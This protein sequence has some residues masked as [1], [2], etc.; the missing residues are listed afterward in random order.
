MNP[1]S[2]LPL[3]SS[4]GRKRRRSWVGEGKAHIEVKTA[5]RE[6]SESLHERLRH[7]LESLDGVDW[8]EV[9]AVAGRVVVA[10]D[11]DVVDP[12]D[13]IDAVEE[14]EEAHGVDAE[15]FSHDAAEHPGD[16][17]TVRRAVL[18]L[19]ADV[20]AV[21]VSFAGALLRSTPIPVE[22]GSVASFVDEQP[23]VRRV[24]EDA[25]GPTVADL[26]LALGNAV[27][28]ALSQGP[29]GLLVDAL[30]RVN[31]LTAARANA[32]VWAT[33]EPAL[34]ATPNRLTTAPV[35]RVPRPRP[36]PRGPV[37]TYQ[38]RASSASLIGGAITLIA[39]RAPRRAATLMLAG[40]AKPS[41]M[42]RDAFTAQL[43][44]ALADRD[45]IVL[46]SRALGR[47]DRVDTVLVS[48]GLLVGDRVR[49]DSV[50]C[51][52]DVDRAEVHRHVRRLFQPDSP[53]AVHRDR[54]WSL[55]PVSRLAYA[56]SE[57]DAALLESLGAVR[58]LGLCRDERL[59]AVFDTAP[60]TA[61][62]AH[63]L[64]DAARQA[65]HMVAVAGDDLDLVNR[66]H[67]D[68]LVDGGPRLA[69]S[70]RMLQEDGCTV[71]LVSGAD[72]EALVAADVAVG[73]VTDHAPWGAD[74]FCHLLEDARRLVDASDLAQEV[75][76]QGN[77][78]ALSAS[79]VAS[80][81]ALSSP[82]RVAAARATTTI[83]AAALLAMANGTR[84][85]VAWDRRPALGEG[86][87]P[88]WHELSRP[89]VLHMLDTSLAGL[90]QEHEDARRLAVHGTLP[91]PVALLRAIGSELANPFTPVL[92]G[93]ALLS[94][95]VGSAADAAIVLAALGL[96]GVVSGVQR[97]SGEQAV[98]SLL[99][100]AAI[101]THVRRDGDT[102]KLTADRLVS[103]DIVV[104][105][106]G[107]TVPADCRI[108]QV[109]ALE[110]DESSL[111]G[112]SEP[113]DKTARAVF[114]LLVS[115]RSCMLYEGTTIVAGS[116]V[117]VVVATDQETESAAREVAG[118]PPGA[119]V[120]VEQRL[121][122]LGAVSLP[123][124]GASGAVM[125]TS[126]LLWG[127]P[128]REALASAVSLTV[129][130]VP[131]GLPMLATVGQ[132]AAARRLSRQGVLVRNPRAIEALGRAE[133]LCVDKTGTLT[134]GR[135]EVRMVSDG[136]RSVGRDELGERERLVLAAARRA[137]PGTDGERSLPH[138]TDRAVH[139]ASS[140]AEIDE[141]LGA[142][143]WQRTIELPFGPDRPYHA[144]WGTVAGGVRLSVKGAPEYV[145]ERSR[146]WR[147]ADG[148]VAIGEDEL[149]RL[150][151]HV[152]GLARRGLRLLAVAERDLEGEDSSP[153]DPS[154]DDIAGLTL[155][156]FV[157][158]ADPIRETATSAIDGLR[159][160][161]VD[162]VMVTGDHPSTAEGIAAE[163]G[164]LDDRRVVTG[165]QLEAMGDVELDVVLAETSVFARVT[166]RQKV[167]IVAAFQR[168]GR[169]VAMTGDGAND[170]NAMRLADAGIALGAHCAPA[171]RTAADVIITDNRIETIVETII[172]G[173]ALWAAVRD[174]L[175]ILVGGNL[176]EIAF[177]LLSGGLGRRPSLS[178]RQILL[179]NLL[180]DIAPSLAIAA[181]PPANRSPEQLAQEGPDRSLGTPLNRAIVQ[182]AA[183]T[184][185][186]ASTAWGIARLSGRPKRAGT[187]GLVA[188]VGTQ[189]GQTLVMGRGDPVV[190]A[191]AVGSAALLAAIVET[192][193]L[194]QFFDCTPLGPV[195]WTT[196]I[197]AS[198][199][200]TAAAQYAPALIDR[201]TP[202]I[203]ELQV[204]ATA[205]SDGA[206]R[207]AQGLGTAPRL[208][209][210]GAPRPRDS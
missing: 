198:A 144:T 61:R 14:I 56:A 77:A 199:A 180:T 183:V 103:G 210:V 178:T 70:V 59:L 82:I 63:Q 170:A 107:E 92:V 29:L 36:L 32:R 4:R 84:A 149:A 40:M 97:F 108:L 187:V 109:N 128:L 6:G 160:A 207:V 31:V 85:A 21:G 7:G 126:Q 191:A 151:E 192:P 117:A 48:Q 201:M 10:F 165:T 88:R 112:E 122:A 173:R 24:V 33:H 186:G 62:G 155:L 133:V 34:V 95:T 12:A 169:P 98:R 154:D 189:L 22:V 119:D 43:G 161:G 138:F 44:R 66:L 39:T 124:A 23:K 83:N 20:I 64:L 181:R 99:S 125:A 177:I 188:L 179:V 163:L 47:L 80:L 120:G 75:A 68:L 26:G 157:A 72:A 175:A 93:G 27:G 78:V 115:E 164:I 140:R 203:A 38:E 182:R 69:D 152:D 13:L 37:E 123:V 101:N 127:R 87:P 202:I 131:E 190:T 74:V 197:T 46:D 30:Y 185:L 168:N 171:A 105:G 141:P 45:V 96:N 73:I 143:G 121:R 94:A 150:A 106:A 28:M 147:H 204:P 65:G 19:G 54:G 167:R 111:T 174:A 145:I 193:G 194:S 76:R 81:L 51:P 132:L 162:I 11:G 86:E 139:R 184:T 9:N 110:V 50:L 146:L 41:R 89:E 195:G 116:A 49:P 158:L 2:W 15:R 57:E 166:P 176:G 8:A 206:R 209:D 200:A 18:A 159:A 60:E 114:G 136:R 55:G 67:A 35:P 134:E 5:Q 100:T 79:S 17:E 91:A 205:V 130:A 104:L 135:V 129:A 25:V 90:T 52:A 58:P 137:S 16:G 1:V 172:E 53:E 102:V 118:A 148:E 208:L 3:P 156:G 71:L 196:A 113:V 142:E 153:A 42:G